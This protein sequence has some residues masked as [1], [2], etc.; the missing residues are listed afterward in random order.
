MIRR[1]L[2]CL[3][4]VSLA[5]G[6]Y[7][8]LAQLRVQPV[9]EHPGKTALE[10]TL[11]RLGSSGTF[12]ETTAHPDDE[13]NGLLAMLGH[14]QGMR[15]VLVSAT[16][17][18]GGQNEIGP[19]LFQ[20]LGVLRTEELHAV[21]RF[22]GAEQRFTRAVD[23]GYSFSID[24]TFER[25]GREAIVGDFVRHIRTVRPDVIAAFLCGG[26]GG[27]QHHQASTRLTAEAFDAAADPSKFPGQFEEG[28]RPWQATRLFCTDISGFGPPR[29]GPAPTPDLLTVDTSGFDPL[30]GRTHAEIG[31]EARSMHK[32]Q[33]TSQLLMLPG[34]TH[35]RTYRLIDSADGSTEA[36][37]SLFAGIDTTLAGLARFAPGA[38][39]TLLPALKEIERLIA[40]ARAQLDREGPTAAVPPLVGGLEAVRRLR[41]SLGS[42]EEDARYEVDFRLARKESEFTEAVALAAGLRLDAIAA[43]G[44]V[45]A[46]Q[47]VAV[48]AYAATDLPQPIALRAVRLQGGA[49]E[50]AGCAATLQRGRPFSCKAELQVPAEAPLSSPY[51]E[52]APDAARYRF[53]P[54]VPFGVPFAPTPF[55][56]TFHFAIDGTEL[57]VDRPIQFRYDHVLAGEKRMDLQVV[58][59]VAVSLSPEIV[60][61][62]AGQAADRRVEARLTNHARGAANVTVVLEVPDG[63]AAEPASVPVELAREDEQ[64][65][66]PFT[67]TPSRSAGPGEAVVRASIRQEDG[68]TTPGVGYQ[69]IEYAHIRRQ[70]LVEP[71]AARL[72]VID[73]AIEPGLEVG[74]IMG[75]GDEVPQAIAQLGAAVRLITPEELAGGDLGR[76]DAIVT[77][78]RAY[79]RR[80]DLRAGNHRL[81][82]YARDGGTVIVQYNK[83]EFNEAQYGPY[84]ARV[85]SGRVT[86]EAAPVE[87][88]APEHPV[89]NTPNR[90]GP[91]AWAGWVQERGLY[92]LGEKDPRYTDL[93]RL[94]DPFPFNPG[95]RTGALVEAQVGKGRWIYLGLGL[96]RQL[97]AG[98]DGAYQLLANLLSLGG[99]R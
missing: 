74:Y 51:W 84:P 21:H 35:N 76:F 85:G 32:C 45:V 46:G 72:K 92:F 15:T 64:V 95:P 37:R 6:S 98:T 70:H 65:T 8:L 43:D 18:E 42:L 62:P 77:G 9:A 29:P 7:D 22:D 39:A 11:R 54:G 83:F 57:S 33:G 1:S 97:P 99:A 56:A 96:W 93:V 40:D 58:P 44:L 41:A 34:G 19:E 52:P 69:V 20:A 73:V 86:D 5:A 68:R 30:L 63:W 17:G 53:A 4:L 10:L 81:L 26:E 90:I 25:W 55:V 49:G 16:R 82:A 59:P 3:A 89:F 38:D 79:E 91:E 67:L 87:V 24:E 47:P 28:L 23:F 75:V 71:A 27:G 36:P 31:L 80:P 88:L 50:G 14:G 13:D 78:V 12:M 94:V 2:A 61:A 48:S 60:V 66:V